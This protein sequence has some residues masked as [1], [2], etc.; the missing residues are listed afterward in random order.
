MPGRHPNADALRDDRRRHRAPQR[1][2]TRGLAASLPPRLPSPASRLRAAGPRVPVPP[3]MSRRHRDRARDH[4]DLA[5]HEL[6]ISHD[7]GN[8]AAYYLLYF[9]EKRNP[10]RSRRTPAPRP[11]TPA[12]RPAHR[13]PRAG[14]VCQPAHGRHG[15]HAPLSQRRRVA[16]LLA[17]F[18]AA[19]RWRHRRGTTR[20]RQGP[21]GSRRSREA[22]GAARPR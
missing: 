4:A 22:S 7:H 2:C 14:A 11:A 9:Q 21:A 15:H 17:A 8:S 3:E 10:E 20:P 13:A 5:A 19:G 12:P 1:R 18:P 6:R 16:A